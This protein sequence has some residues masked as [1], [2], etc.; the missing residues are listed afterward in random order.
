M[1]EEAKAL[2]E[3]YETSGVLDIAD[4]LIESLDAAR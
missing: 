3:E 2:L 1:D 4:Q